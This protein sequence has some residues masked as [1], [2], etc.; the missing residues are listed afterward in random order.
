MAKATLTKSCTSFKVEGWEEQKSSLPLAPHS[1]S[2]SGERA[3]TPTRHGCK[4][5]RQLSCWSNPPMLGALAT[6]LSASFTTL[7]PPLLSQDLI[8]WRM[9]TTKD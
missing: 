8:G 6:L 5:Y 3:Q 4:I 1:H 2:H 7:P 9:A